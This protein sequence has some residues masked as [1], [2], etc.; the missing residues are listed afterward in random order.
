M[1][2][3]GNALL[4]GSVPLATSEEVFR[5]ASTLG[6]ALRRIP[7]G[8]TGDR[9]N[10]IGWQIGPIGSNPSMEP[11]PQRDGYAPM[12]N[13]QLKA[14]VD[15]S[16]ITFDDLGYATAAIASW[17]VFEPLQLEGVIPASTRFQVS[18][19]TPVAPVTGYVDVASQPAV[20]AAY[21]VRMLQELAEIC[22][23]VPHERLALQW[24]VA[25]E[26]GII[27]GAFPSY[28]SG[29]AGVAGL[30]ERLVRIGNAV[31]EDVEL[32]FH[33]CY[34]D[35]GHQHFKE[36]TDTATLVRIANGIADGVTRTIQ[37]VHL[38][39]PRDRDDVAYFAPLANLN[40]PAN[41]E[42]YLGLVHMT[43]GLEG[44]QRRVAAARQ[45]ITDFGVATECGF[46]RRPPETVPALVALHG[47]LLAAM[48]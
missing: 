31:P 2:G 10:W 24:D 13:F 38:P 8:E 48:A 29:E 25:V 36:P 17:E 34:G 15:P 30:L 14:D 44:A 7:D 42:L 39:V 46:G 9:T 22:A 1:A 37:W 45:V 6:T 35:Y 12:V 23:V 32:G 11:V 21:E 41:T 43:D 47:D 27:E 5:V 40:L 18:L 33:L 20:E 26:F 4:V 28:L 16:Q 3:S 19:P